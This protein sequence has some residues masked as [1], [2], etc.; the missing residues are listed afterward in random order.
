MAITVLYT[1]TDAIRS[2]IGVD[3]ADVPDEI[4]TG[5]NMAMQMEYEL[6]KIFPTHATDIYSNVLI[7]RKLQLWCMWFGG[8]RIAESPPAVA[9]RYSTGK[10]EFERFVIDWE[11]LAAKARKKLAELEEDLVPTAVANVTLMGKATPAYN[12]ITGA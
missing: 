8:L 5:Q 3:D 6:D 7:E 2:V 4:I 1:D 11:A 9:K 12:P 10:D